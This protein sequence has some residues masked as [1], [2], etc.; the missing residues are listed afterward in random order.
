LVLLRSVINWNSGVYGHRRDNVG[1][2]VRF[3]C[4]ASS[5]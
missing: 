1:V 4:A 5:Y 2:F 3:T